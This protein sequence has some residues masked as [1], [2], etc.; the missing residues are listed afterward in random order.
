MYPDDDRRPPVQRIVLTGFMGAGKSTVGRLLANALGWRFLDA[1]TC[2][3]AKSGTLV[4]EIFRTRGEAAFRRL[5]AE[6]VAELHEESGLVLALGGG[7]IETESTR[8]LLGGTPGTWMVFL[9]A[10]FDV[11]IARCENQLGAAERPVLSQRETLL[12]RFHLRMHHYEQAHLIVATEGL[13][14]GKVV[15]VI[16]YRLSEL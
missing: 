3:E 6:I 8:V 7:A 15:D 5:E 2:L 4:A 12:D 16:L 1:D 9:Q 11:L 14:P 10:P 13:T